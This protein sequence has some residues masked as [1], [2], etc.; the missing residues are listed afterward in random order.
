MRVRSGFPSHQAWSFGLDWIFV[1]ERPSFQMPRRPRHTLAARIMSRL[2]Q[3][4]GITSTPGE[5]T[6]LYL[7]REHRAAAELVAGWMREAGLAVSIDDAGTVVGRVEG[8]QRASK[9]LLLGS[10]ID[11]V[12][13][14]GR[15]DGCLGVVLGI[16]V[17]AELRRLGQHLPFAVE[18]LAFGDEEGVRFPR[19]LTGSRAVAGALEVGQLEAVDEAGIAMAAAL[20][21]FGCEPSRIA[22]VARRQSDILGYVEVHIE[23]GPVLEKETMAVGVVTA[24]SGAS[25]FRIEVTGRA[26]HAGTLPMSMR[27][28]ALTGAAEM[29]LA[30]ESVGRGMPGMVATVGQIS[31]GPGAVNVV[32]GGADFSLDVRSP[33][34]GTR[35]AGVREIDR[36]IRNVAKR[37]QL[38][39]RIEEFYNER[40]VSC[41]QRLIRHMS[42]AAERVGAATLMLPSGAGHDGLALAKLCPIGMLFVRCK[43]GISHHP[44]ES[45]EPEDVEIAARV[46]LDFLEH[47][48]PGGRTLS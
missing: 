13:N 16:E 11:T 37:R 15:F 18:V 48:S 39:V 29:V 23:Q 10:H 30:I 24:I 22:A 14:A 20:A 32:P 47:L 27:R 46:M 6:R 28:D 3:L 45:V 31:A 7:T 36:Q 21:E 17:M 43:G 40:A 12:R 41:D 38:Q 26:G 4:A 34:D 1:K 9:T 5:I 42:A 44:D 8:A 25:R 35:R 33:V 19:T 2:D